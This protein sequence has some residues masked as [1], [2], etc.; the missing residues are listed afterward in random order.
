MWLPHHSSTWLSDAQKDAQES[1]LWINEH[2][3]EAAASSA[4]SPDLVT[5]PVAALTLVLAI[6]VA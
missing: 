1:S 6:W 3:T 5:H 4:L 2:R